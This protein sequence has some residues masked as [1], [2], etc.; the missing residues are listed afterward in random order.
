M[1]LYPE[2]CK[3]LRPAE[4]ISAVRPTESESTSNPGNTNYFDVSNDPELA[5][6]RFQEIEQDWFISDRRLCHFFEEAFFIIDDFGSDEFSRHYS[7]LMDAFL[8]RYNLRYMLLRP[9]QLTPTIPGM[10]AGSAQQLD[11]KAETNEHLSGLKK[12]LE[13][14]VE[15]LSKDGRL[16]DVHK[17]IGNACNLTEGLARSFPG[18]KATTLG[19]LAKELDVWPHPTLKEA[20]L[21]LYGFC[22]N[23]PGIR[24][25]GH[26]T[27][28]LRELTIKDAFV[29][30]ALLLAFSGYFINDLDIEEIM[31]L[32]PGRPR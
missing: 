1:E 26:P 3:A 18:A 31:C 25:S 14:A 4:I 13:R 10:L 9:F 19:D 29:V 15:L 28:S 32:S 20:L 8:R 16:E 5:R 22:S 23:Y 2:L 17:C 21:K 12:H 7:I 24:H 27:G 30:S 6:S 11:A